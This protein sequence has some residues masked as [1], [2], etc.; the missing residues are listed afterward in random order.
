VYNWDREQPGASMEARVSSPRTGLYAK[1]S[2][3][4]KGAQFQ[5]SA[6]SVADAADLNVDKP[7]KYDFLVDAKVS[8]EFAKTDVKFEAEAKL[9]DG[10]I[11]AKVDGSLAE[12]K[13]ATVS[14][15]IELKP[16]PLIGGLIKSKP[17][18]E[19]D[20]GFDMTVFGSGLYDSEKGAL[21]V[22]GLRANYSRDVEAP[23]ILE[24]KLKVGVEVGGATGKRMVD[25]DML[26]SK[27]YLP[28][29]GQVSAEYELDKVRLLGK[30]YFRVEVGNKP[31]PG[32]LPT[33][34]IDAS[35]V[36]GVRKSIIGDVNL[37]AT[38]SNLFGKPAGTLQV[39]WDLSGLAETAADKF[40][41]VEKRGTKK[42][43]P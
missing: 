24:G 29:F 38:G 9:L 27:Y 6:R 4:L 5:V 17:D 41:K 42:F 21:G 1:A 40:F 20:I 12:G 34:F 2:V 7:K 10:A 18:G 31:I 14:S 43:F 39:E 13:K 23:G 15:S 19:P 3:D 25:T 32:E 36:L 11:L 22:Y 30:A 33:R 35:G 26:R 37:K 28:V 16:L 8:C